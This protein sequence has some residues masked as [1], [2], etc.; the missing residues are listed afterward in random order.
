[1]LA[2]G[3]TTGSVTLAS[4]GDARCAIVTPKEDAAL[5]PISASKLAAYFQEH[6]GV[7]PPIL[8]SSDMTDAEPHE[9]WIVLDAGENHPLLAKLGVKCDVPVDRVDA[10]H[11]LIVPHGK[12]Q[13]IALAG[14]SAA[15]VKFAAYR[16]M[17]EMEIDQ[18]DVRVGPLD[19]RAS[20]FFRTRSV[21][22]FNIWRVPVDVIRRC[23]L[24]SWPTEKVQRSIDIYDAFGFNAVETHDRFHEDFLKAVYG[25]SRAQ[26]RDK[27]YARATAPPRRND[28]FPAALGHFCRPSG[29]RAEDGSPRLDLTT[30]LRTS[31]KNARAGDGDPRLRVEKL[32]QP[33]RSPD[34]ALGRRWRRASGF[35][36]TVKDSVLLHNELVAAFWAINP[37]VASTF[38]LWGMAYLRGKRGWPGYDDHRSIC[39]AGILP[40]V[41]PSR[42]TTR[43]RSI[44]Y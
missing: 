11:L 12:H 37:K 40:K 42:N 7:Q 21:S 28:G 25:I 2:D 36:A 34:R 8:S 1:M 41:S 10:Y 44:V 29:E 26:R 24:E 30:S 13:I 23:N 39:D 14:R 33:R 38:N 5:A 43:A 17:E 22:L 31:L 19:V 9:T 3:A 6:V 35:H 4:N 27:V 15:G 18:H 16:F 20:P 32:C